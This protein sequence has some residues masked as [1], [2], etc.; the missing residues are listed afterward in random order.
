MA[1]ADW[2]GLSVVHEGF[3]DEV[4]RRRE[5]SHAQPVAGD[6]TGNSASATRPAPLN[7]AKLKA[8]P[9]MASTASLRRVGSRTV[10]APGTCS[11]TMTKRSSHGP[12]IADGRERIWRYVAL[13]AVRGR[14]LRRQSL[15]QSRDEADRA[16]R[17]TKCA[18]KRVKHPRAEVDEGDFVAQVF[19]SGDGEP[20]R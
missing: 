15:E 20:Q 7:S 2:C 8:L 5:L 3:Q 11:G 14:E 17:H 19:T 18:G 10:V 1:A 16:L 9:I 6:A 12:P 4:Y 13:L